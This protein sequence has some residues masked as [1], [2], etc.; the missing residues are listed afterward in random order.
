[1][2]SRKAERF[3]WVNVSSRAQRALRYCARQVGPSGE[4]G[5]TVREFVLELL[6]EKGIG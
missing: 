3:P 6:R 2:P 1:V 5:K 4:E